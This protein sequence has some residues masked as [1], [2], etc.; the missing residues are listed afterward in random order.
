VQSASRELDRGPLYELLEHA[1]IHEKIVLVAA[2]KAL[3]HD[4]MQIYAK[5]IDI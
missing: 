4:R 2:V 5:F 1:T 3:H